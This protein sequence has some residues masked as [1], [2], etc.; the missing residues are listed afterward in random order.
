MQNPLARLNVRVGD[1]T[2]IPS[3]PCRRPGTARASACAGDGQVRP[4][5]WVA[6]VTGLFCLTGGPVGMQLIDAGIGTAKDTGLINLPLRDL[7]HN[8]TG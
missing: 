6:A 1:V 5:G 3:D 8:K 2:S 4:G 7:G